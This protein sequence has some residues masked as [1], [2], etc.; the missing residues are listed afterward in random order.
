[1]LTCIREEIRGQRVEY[2]LSRSVVCA[3]NPVSDPM[4]QG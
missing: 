1:M 2:P 4:L 3:Y